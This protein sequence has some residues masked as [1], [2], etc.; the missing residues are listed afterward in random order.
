MSLRT[1]STGIVCA[2]ISITAVL[3][4]PE[5]RAGSVTHTGTFPLSPYLNSGSHTFPPAAI[6]K[7]DLA[8]QC[9][10]SV[11]VRLDGGVDGLIGF[12][13]FQNFPTIVTVIFT[14]S[15][16]LQRP[17]LSTLLVVQP[18]ITTTDSV[19]SYDGGPD[20]GGTSG[21]T[22]PSVGAAASDSLCLTQNADLALF[23]GA[24]SINLPGFTTDLASQTGASSW[25]I[26]VR[27]YATIRVT[28]NYI[29]CVVPVAS[30][31]WS[32][33]KSLYR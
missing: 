7:F 14:G 2:L 21:R 27:G 20:Y 12:E 25:S 6:P 8:G 33:I 3:T 9:L 29:D 10:T 11:C 16:T 30:T 5:A 26:G 13:N 18:S 23:S 17:D 4:G 28:Y 22:Y 15:I 1:L 32:R 24:G 19:T 31:S